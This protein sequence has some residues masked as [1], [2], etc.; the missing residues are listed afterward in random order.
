MISPDILTAFFKEAEALAAPQS[1]DA[2]K[3]KLSQAVKNQ[4]PAKQ[5][6]LPSQHVSLPRDHQAVELGRQS[7]A[8]TAAGMKLGAMTPDEARR[9][10]HAY[11]IKNR[12]RQLQKSKQYRLKNKAVIARKKKLYNRQVA[13]G[14]KKQ[15]RRV[16]QGSHSYGYGGWK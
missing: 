4:A 12:H 9:R 3:Q 8:L 2:A 10:R 1:M 5:H 16:Q 6:A 13:T 7:A 15:R 14:T 11:Y